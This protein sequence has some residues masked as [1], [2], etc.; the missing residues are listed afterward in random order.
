VLIQRFARLDGTVVA[1]QS[2]YVY[3]SVAVLLIVGAHLLAGRRLR[4]WLSVAVVLALAGV[5]A[6]LVVTRDAGNALRRIG[7]ETRGRIAAVEIAARTIS[8][9]FNLDSFPGGGV[10]NLQF[11]ANFREAAFQRAVSEVGSEPVPLGA[12]PGLGPAGRRE[13]D[14]V[15]VRAL[16]VRMASGPLVRLSRTQRRACTRVPATTTSSSLPVRD[17]ATI[18]TSGQAATVYLRRFADPGTDTQ[19]G[20]V[21]ARTSAALRIPADR[22]S[23][24]W[25]VHVTSPANVAVCA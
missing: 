13:V 19:I 12:V 9:D 3:P 15:L 21:A 16:S 11:V 24:P 1:A 10:R 17:G 4:A 6:N 22:S 25:V 2:R 7:D 23:R 14:A 18:R 8:P 20:T 5:V